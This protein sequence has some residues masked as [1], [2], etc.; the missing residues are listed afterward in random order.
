MSGSLR[1][2]P[3]HHDADKRHGRGISDSHPDAPFGA[4]IFVRPTLTE[5]WTAAAEYQAAVVDEA[6]QQS[7]DL[8]PRFAVFSLSPIPLAIHLGHQL[9]HRVE[10]RP[11]QFDRDRKTWDATCNAGDT[12]FIVEGVPEKRD[13]S[14]TDVIV[15]VSLSARIDPQDT[16]GYGGDAVPEIDLRIAEPNVMWLCH[17]DQLPALA[18]A[19]RQVLANVNAAALNCVRIHL[20]YAGP[21]GGAITLGQA[22]NPRMSPSVV[23]YEYDRRASPR[24]LPVLALG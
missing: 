20:F 3:R 23:L 22:I 2:D 15:R 21:P 12:D 5:S 24:Y 17:P 9:S 11:F 1:D 4:P 14:T 16:A 7:K 10:V 13:A 19:F 6:I 18:S 8:L